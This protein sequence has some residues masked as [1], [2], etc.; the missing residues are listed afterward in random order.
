[1]V[2]L[3]WSSSCSIF[4]MES[5]EKFWSFLLSFFDRSESGPE[6]QLAYQV[7]GRLELFLLV[8][9]LM[10]VATFVGGNV[11]FVHLSIHSNLWSQFANA[12]RINPRSYKTYLELT[13][14]L[15][16]RSARFASYNLKQ[17][18]LKSVEIQQLFLIWL[19]SFTMAISQELIIYF[20]NLSS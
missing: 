9:Y 10:T 1:M 17:F 4:L 5:Q 3:V 2:G 20:L 15:T 13:S 8:N 18:N 14:R 19:D 11:P 7:L 6:E 12:L 16:A